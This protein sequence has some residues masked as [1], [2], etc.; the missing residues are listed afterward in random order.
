MDKVEDYFRQWWTCRWTRWRTTRRRSRS[1]G[2]SPRWTRTWSGVEFGVKSDAGCD[3]SVDKGCWG[4]VGWWLPEAPTSTSSP[5]QYPT[6]PPITFMNTFCLYNNQLQLLFSPIMSF[7]SL[8]TYLVTRSFTL[9]TSL[10]LCNF[11][12]NNLLNNINHFPNNLQ[13][14]YYHHRQKLRP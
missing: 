13:K 12:L 14:Q 11:L 6:S 2:R 1:P 7:S 8:V 5:R 3:N 10:S 9:C 4:I